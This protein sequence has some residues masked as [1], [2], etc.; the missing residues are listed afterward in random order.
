MATWN[1]IQNSEIAVDAPVTS[2]VVTK[3]RDNLDAVTEGASGAP[4]VLRPA[5]AS[6]TAGDFVI[7]A[8]MLFKSGG[9]ISSWTTYHTYKIY[10]NCSIKLRSGAW[11]QDNFQN[12]GTRFLINGADAKAQIYSTSGGSIAETVSLSQG[13]VVEFQA[14]DLETNASDSRFN[15]WIGVGNPAGLF[16]ANISNANSNQ[17]STIENIE[18]VS[19]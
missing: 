10:N 6:A 5:F 17:N 2:Q 12:V 4:K 9:S 18:Y 15:W 1:T 19:I 7:L 13:D 8:K 14:I 16:G 3:M 11:Q